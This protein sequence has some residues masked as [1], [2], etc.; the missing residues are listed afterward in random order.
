MTDERGHDLLILA[1]VLSVAAHVATMFFMR[2]QVM[3]HVSAAGARSRARAPMRVREAKPDPGVVSLDVVKDVAPERDEPAPAVQEAP[4]AGDLSVAPADDAPAPDAPDAPDAP[5]PVMEVENVEA[6]SERI[7]VDATKV[8]SYQPPESMDSF[9]APAAPEPPTPVAPAPE[10]DAKPEIPEIAPPPEDVTPVFDDGPDVA[11][12][13]DPAIESAPPT[14]APFVPAEEVMA[15]L[16]ERLVE[17]EKSAVRGLLDVRTAEELSG[18]VSMSASSTEADGWTYFKVSI[19]PEPTLKI[20]SK[21][22]VLLIDA[23]GSIAN[24]RLKSCRSAAKEILRTC[25]N[26]GDR[27]NLVAFRDDFEYAFKT[28]RECDAPSYE[29]AEEWMDKLAAH[30]R[31]DVFATIASVLKLP[32]DPKRPLIALVITDGDANEGVYRTS[33]ILSK[34]TALNDGLVSVFMYG[35]KESANREL[36]DALTRGNRGESY[37]YGGWRKFAGR[38]LGDLSEKFRDP[39][40]TDL[41]VVFAADSGVEAYPRLLKNLY[42]GEIVDIVGRAPAGAKEIAFSLKGLNGDTAYEGFF[43]F[44]LDPSPDNARIAGEWGEDRDI[45]RKIH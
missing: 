11:A 14:G 29:A 45:D 38:R 19:S 35:V 31:T 2:P 21:D 23:S 7:H 40:L 42:R 8:L 12:M 20:A 15:R 17:A 24:D 27:F 32:R 18:H 37:I 16:D 34:F 25:M 33:S 1:L 9:S 10:P 44:A 5:V 39:A 30:G 41:R 3:A 13:P 36:I 43:R 4:V 22:V 26:S 28:W 6:L